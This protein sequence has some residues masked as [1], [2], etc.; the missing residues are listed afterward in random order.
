MGISRYDVE[1]NELISDD[2]LEYIPDTCPECGSDIEFTDTLKSIY[3]TNSR[4][5]AKIAARLESMAKAMK[6][7][8]WG[9]STC[10]EVVRNFKMI[11]PYQVFLLEK[12]GVT[13]CP[14]VSAFIKKIESICDMERRKLKLWEVVR[15]GGIP[16]IET[17]AFKIFDGFNSISEAY[18]QIE[19]QQVPFIAD[20]L[21]LK[22]SEG[23][24]MA[25][26]IYN[27]LIEYKQELLFAET[28][29]DIYAPK[30]EKLVF[31]ITGGVNGFRNK[32]EFIDYVNNRYKGKVD[33][34]LLN[35]V[36]ANVDYLISDGDR[37]SNKMKAAM[38]LVNKGAKIK[39]VDSTEIIELLD[40]R[41]N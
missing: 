16:G 26:S 33:A 2:I 24:V 39:I 21:G 7:E 37:E 34:V 22:N 6:A 4:C 18:E 41:F 5:P 35:S 38:K 25:V 29:F 11:S 1:V 9:E 8:G 20:R 27:T 31:V 30:G 15:L 13:S 40:T 12:Q 10:L 19:T 36:S 32:S 3:C 28:M 14:N 17:T 23:G